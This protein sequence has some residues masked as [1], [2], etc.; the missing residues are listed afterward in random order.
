MECL[1]IAPT[2]E[3]RIKITT[4][5]DVS[6]LEKE[7]E[8]YKYV[9][10]RLAPN[11]RFSAE[12]MAQI[13][14]N[15]K[16]LDVNGDGR[17]CR[18]ELAE[19]LEKQEAELSEEDL[20][21]I[22]GEADKDESGCINFEEFVALMADNFEVTGDELL[23]TFRLFDVDDNGTLSEAEVLTVMKALGMWP[24]KAQV[25]NLMQKADTDNNGN[26]SYEELVDFM[27]SK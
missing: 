2:V 8:L 14:Q 20:D 4:E 1:G 3:G 24:S 19:A 25:K 6:R 9:E 23:D 26:I 21:R 10:D 12:E 11:T 17:I 27:K 16:L 5:E 13:E 7:K 18:S 22:W 15:F